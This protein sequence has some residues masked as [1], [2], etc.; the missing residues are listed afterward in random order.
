MNF[1]TGQ[2]GLIFEQNTVLESLI[3]VLFLFLKMHGHPVYV[4]PYLCLL[5]SGSEQHEGLG[6]FKNE[7]FRLVT[8]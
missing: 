6:V 3:K 1:P 2:K 5:P 7:Y 8:K 4:N